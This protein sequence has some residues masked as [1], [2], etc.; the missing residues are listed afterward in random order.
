MS[1]MEL[2][3]LKLDRNFV[4]HETSKIMDLSI[5]NDVVNMAHRMRLAVV[6]EG[7]ESRSQLERLRAMGCDYVQG[8]YFAKPMPAREF[9]KLLSS[10]RLL[11]PRPAP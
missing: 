5:L 8:F 2:D 9:E 1:Q 6:A 7:V 4:I 11:E 10:S 3:V